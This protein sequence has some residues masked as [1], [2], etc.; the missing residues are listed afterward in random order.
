MN[1]FGLG[2]KNWRSI[3]NVVFSD[4][5]TCWNLAW[6]KVGFMLSHHWMLFSVRFGLIWAQ[7]FIKDDLLIYFILFY[8]FL[9]PETICQVKC[10]IVNESI[11]SQHV[12]NILLRR[13]GL[14]LLDVSGFNLTRPLFALCFRLGLQPGLHR[15]GHGEGTPASAQWGHLHPDV[16]TPSHDPVCLQSQPGPRGPRQRPEIHLL[17]AACEGLKSKTDH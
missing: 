8:F 11:K 17:I 16:W 3:Q 13:H 14:W 12:W 9:K 4:V 6:K 2:E 10:K 7:K 5:Q 15:W 1:Y